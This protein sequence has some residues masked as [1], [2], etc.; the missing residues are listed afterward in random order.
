MIRPQPTPS[1]LEGQSADEY[2]KN[3]QNNHRQNRHPNHLVSRMDERLLPH[4]M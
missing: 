3:I 2:S 4:K 1:I